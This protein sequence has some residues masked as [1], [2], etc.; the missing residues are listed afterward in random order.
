MRSFP[1]STKK[2]GMLLGFGIILW[3]FSLQCLSNTPIVF[4]KETY[5]YLRTILKMIQINLRKANLISVGLA[6]FKII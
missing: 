2:H 5:K 3:S 1:W 6:V 4:Q